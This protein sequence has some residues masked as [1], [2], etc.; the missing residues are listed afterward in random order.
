MTLA[1]YF[2]KEKSGQSLQ[3]TLNAVHS[4]IKQRATAN[5]RTN[6]CQTLQDFLNHA[7]YPEKYGADDSGQDYRKTIETLIQKVYREKMDTQIDHFS[8]GM[9]EIHYG[10]TSERLPTLMQNL[11]ESFSHKEKIYVATIEDRLQR[12]KDALK[13]ASSISGGEI[14]QY[15]K[16]LLDLQFQLQELANLKGVAVNAGTDK[17][18]FDLT[19]K[20][21]NLIS[22]IN[23]TDKKFKALSSVGGVFGPQEYGQVLEWILQAFS[24]KTDRAADEIAEQMVDDFFKTAG[25]SPTKSSHDFIKVSGIKFDGGKLSKSEKK[26]GESQQV[27]ITNDQGGKVEFNWTSSFAPDKKRQGK[28]DVDFKFNDPKNERVIPFRIS[29]KNWRTLDRDFGETNVIYAL[30]RSADNEGAINYMLAMQDPENTNNIDLGHQLAKYS[31]VV[32]ILMGLSQEGHFADTLVINVRE[33]KRVIVGSVLDI[34]DNIWEKIKDF[35]L[36]GYPASQIHRELTIIRTALGNMDQ[37]SE[38]Y[39]SLGMKYLQTIKVALHY[40]SIKNSIATQPTPSLT[41]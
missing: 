15:R 16:D 36:P 4:K 12:V 32:D 22:L 23:S 37:K 39:Y 20:N 41:N 33:E 38:T 6:E 7:F 34:L 18:F 29:A 27:T 3:E 10:D 17:A 26:D 11:H 40:N 14:E 8:M 1:E 24:E 9:T 21:Q 30:L 5:I 28:M 19:D 13:K 31:L 2:K 35:D 25:S